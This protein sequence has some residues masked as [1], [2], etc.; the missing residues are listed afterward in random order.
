MGTWTPW[1]QADYTKQIARG[2]VSYSTPG[3][4][5]I[6]VSPTKQA[7]MPE[8]LRIESGWYE[9]DCDWALVALAFP[10]YFIA[11]YSQALDTVKN[12]HP[13]RYEKWSGV[14]LKPEESYIKKQRQ[15]KPC[16]ACNGTGKQDVVAQEI[17]VVDGKTVMVPQPAVHM[18]CFVC[19]GTGNVSPER[20]AQLKKMDEA[21]CKCEKSSGSS[22]YQHGH[23]HGWVCNDCGKITQV[24]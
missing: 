15:G 23:S 13:D 22:Y 4:G 10:E 5:G 21:W 6:H 16:T 12:W 19:Q 3:H 18:D 9:E 24:G 11:E 7:K 20:E 17:K 2:I 14:T 8:A 1:G